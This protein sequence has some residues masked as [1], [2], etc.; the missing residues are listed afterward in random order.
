MAKIKICGLFRP[1]DIDIVNEALPDFAG[2]VF[3]PSRRR[4]T[5]EWAREQCAR[6]DRRI[7]TVGVFVDDFEHYDFLDYV[8]VYEGSSCR[9]FG[10]GEAFPVF[11]G[12]QPGSGEAFDWST[13]P[14]CGGPWFLAGGINLSNIREAVATGA[15]C[16]D[17]S[18]GAETDDVKDLKSVQA[19]V[20]A[21]RKGGENWKTK[22]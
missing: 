22:T 15:W 10:N 3:A 7:K 11:D 17:V 19:L 20:E 21:V 4:V 16:V 14:V 2:F 8:Q 6:L 1:E 9:V 12:P 13:I 5:P 18:S